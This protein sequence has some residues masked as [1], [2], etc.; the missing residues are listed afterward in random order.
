MPLD[1]ISITGTILTIKSYTSI[2]C[3]Q[4]N[5]FFLMHVNANNITIQ[6]VGMYITITCLLVV[7][8][9]NCPIY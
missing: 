2:Y 6:S 8:E 7:S 5:C 3:G 4:T 1:K 9:F